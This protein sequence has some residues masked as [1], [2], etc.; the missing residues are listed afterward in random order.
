M[1]VFAPCVCLVPTKDKMALD[2]LS[3]GAD[4]HELPC[5]YWESNPGLP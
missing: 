4:N 2:S 1:Y 5:G 3:G